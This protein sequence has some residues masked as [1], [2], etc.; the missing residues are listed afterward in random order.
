VFSSYGNGKK[1][2]IS[3]LIRL[4]RWRQLSKG[5]YQA[6][7]AQCTT[8]NEN[9]LV[10]NGKQYAMGRYPDTGYLT[11]MSHIDKESITDENFG[12]TPNWVG[13][14]LVIRKN[15]WIIDRTR[16]EKQSDGTLSYS[17]GSSSQ[18]TDG[19]GYFIQNSKQ[20]LHH[21]GD[22]FFDR[23]NGIFL[24]H[25]GYSTPGLFEVSTSIENYLVRIEGGNSIQFEN[26]CF[27]GASSHTIEIKNS[28]KIYIKNCMIDYSAADGINAS[29]SPELNI[30]YTM[31][32]H[33]LNDAIVLDSSCH[34]ASIRYN[35]I[36]NT[37]M[38]PG[39]GKSGSGTYQAV[40]SFGASSVIEFN[41]I[42][43]T[44]YNGIYFGGNGSV[45]KNNFI[46]NFCM[47]KDDGAGIYI[48]DWFPSSDKKIIGNIVIDGIGAA[49]GAKVQDLVPVEGIYIDD[50][51]SG[52]S[53]QSNSVA[54]CPDA[55]IKIHNANNIQITGNAVFNNGVQLMI[56]HDN[57]H[58]KS[59]NRNL[60]LTGNLFF[61]LRPEQLC[62]NLYSVKNDLDSVGTIDN[63]YYYSPTNDQSI[64]KAVSNIWTPQSV[65]NNFSLSKWKNVHR[66]DAHSI[67]VSKK[68]LTQKNVRFE[69]N[70]SGK[71][72]Q[73]ST[74]A[75]YATPIGIK[76]TN[77]FLIA[78]YQSVIVIDRG[79]IGPN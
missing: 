40:S 56:A 63:N 21:F 78:P 36:K 38:I 64:V 73:I 50:N 72:K 26:L 17:E 54:N 10:I 22:W 55:G 29:G 71:N 33:S 23:P 52:I 76:L 62:V 27:Q 79:A 24:I 9:M 74:N 53:I 3:G 2:I 15:H 31:I 25:F 20:T 46:H 75:Y 32:N 61:A 30:E 57:L 13:S 49:P 47:V 45:V 35:V 60:I 66:Q 1:P 69:Y 4:D 12:N 68:M 48:G 42:D 39:L 51:S 65:T 37:G 14:E 11:Y 58:P 43:T 16:L 19:F 44:G 6:G 18:P 67:M 34:A 41:E 77:K 59:P 5:I 7:C 28:K 8:I 70:A